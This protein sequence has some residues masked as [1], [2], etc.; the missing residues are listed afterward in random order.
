MRHGFGRLCATSVMSAIVDMTSRITLCPLPAKYGIPFD[1][2]MSER[3]KQKDMKTEKEYES[4][5]VEIVEMD[6]GGSVLMTSLTGENI[7]EW[8]EM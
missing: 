1:I 2:C 5:A 7:N 8:E 6:T 3:T 4:P